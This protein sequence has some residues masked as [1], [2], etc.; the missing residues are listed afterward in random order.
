MTL[1]YVGERVCYEERE[2]KYLVGTVVEARTGCGGHCRI[3]LDEPGKVEMKEWHRLD[4]VKEY[5]EI[6]LEDEGYWEGESEEESEEES[7]ENRREKEAST[8]M[9]KVRQVWMVM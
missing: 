7:G 6:Y 9:K 3:E 5:R 8:N 1:K 2:D 4:K